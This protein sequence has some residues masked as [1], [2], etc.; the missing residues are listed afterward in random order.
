MHLSTRPDIQSTRALIVLNSPVPIRTVPT[1]QALEKADGKT[2]ELPWEVY[3]D[4]I[5]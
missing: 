5:V 4:T 1:Y 2:E 3:R